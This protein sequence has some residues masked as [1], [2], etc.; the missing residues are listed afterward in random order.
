MDFELVA[1]VLVDSPTGLGNHAATTTTTL[2]TFLDALNWLPKNGY[3][4]YEKALEG[5][6]PAC[7]WEWR[8]LH[9]SRPKSSAPAADGDDDDDDDPEATAAADDLSGLIIDRI[10]D[11]PPDE[12]KKRKKYALVVRGLAGHAWVKLDA[13][14]DEEEQQQLRI[15]TSHV[16]AEEEIA[17][18]VS[19][20]FRGSVA[21]AV[22]YLHEQGYA[23]RETEMEELY[24][25]MVKDS[26]DSTVDGPLQL[27]SKGI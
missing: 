23:D 20:I 9:F 26:R 19:S 10:D 14:D 16:E 11:Q 24:N 8:R 22:G 25:A 17:S 21:G 15:L 13:G 5:D 3:R 2:G 4:T 6:D 27:Y 1:S 7:R 18:G 12:K